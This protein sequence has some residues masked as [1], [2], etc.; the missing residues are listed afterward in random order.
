LSEHVITEF[1]RGVLLV[2]FNR[3]EKK[4]ALTSEMYSAL[5]DAIEQAN[6]DKAIKV[7][8]FTG[9]EGVFTA[10][11]DVADFL[12]GPP[13]GSGSPVF[14]FID[15]MVR[16]DVPLM[17]AVDGFAVGIGTTML[18]HFDQV[19]ASEDAT[20]SLPFINLALLPEAGSSQLLVEACGYKKAA[21]LLMLGAPFSARDALDCGIISHVSRKEDLMDDAMSMARKLAAKPGSAL[22][23]TKRL[24]RR[25]REP[26][27]ERVRA[28][29]ELFAQQLQ[30]DAAREALSAFMEKR[31]PDFSKFD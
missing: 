24:M 13:A 22:R 3:A 4:N 9:S 26:L 7:V 18:L 30:S 8:L 17:A 23:A 5:A 19:F 15:R 6:E 11:N 14:R 21:G 25:T 2:R 28:E 12:E 27:D 1:D 16:T 29:G 10:G 20:F 31:A